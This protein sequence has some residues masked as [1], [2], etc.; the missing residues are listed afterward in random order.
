MIDVIVDAQVLIRVVRDQHNIV[1]V[2]TLSLLLLLVGTAVPVLR[3]HQ[4]N[5]ID[6]INVSDIEPEHCLTHCDHQTLT[7]L[8]SA[9][10]ANQYYDNTWPW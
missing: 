10:G 8:S 9:A 7:R 4:V 6:M 5:D 3:S 2:F 1:K